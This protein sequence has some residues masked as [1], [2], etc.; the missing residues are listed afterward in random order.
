MAR[1]I[2]QDQAERDL[3]AHADYIAA[4]NPDAA[5]RL[6]SAARST[7]ALL[8]ELPGIG[9]P[10]ESPLPELADLRVHP[11]KGFRKYLI[12]YLPLPD[13]VMVLRVIHASQDVDRFF[14]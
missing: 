3:I 13:G 11:V 14:R 1:R 10:R 5:H 6:L 7:I 12:C 9:A 4:D 2:V 8:A